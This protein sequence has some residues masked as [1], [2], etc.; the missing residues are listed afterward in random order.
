MGMKFHKLYSSL[1]NTV[2]DLVTKVN[3]KKTKL[4]RFNSRKMANN[5]TSKYFALK[6]SCPILA[7]VFKSEHCHVIFVYWLGFSCLCFGNNIKMST[8]NKIHII[9]ELGFSSSLHFFILQYRMK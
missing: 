2:S 3:Q 8:D 1:K 9:C 5:K 7:K 6:W 4:E